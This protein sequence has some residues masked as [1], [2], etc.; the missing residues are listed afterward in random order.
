MAEWKT[1]ITDRTTND[2]TDAKNNQANVS[3][4]KGALNFNDLNRIENNYKYLLDRLKSE[5]YYINHKYRSYTETEAVVEK[6]DDGSSGGKITLP[7]LK[8]SGTQYIDTGFKPNNN[9]RVIMKYVVLSSG[10]RPTQALFGG[11]IADSNAMF[12]MFIINNSYFRP[13]YGAKNTLQITG[14]SDKLV[15]I[16]MNKETTTINGTS[17]SYSSETFQSNYSLTLFGV[18]DGGTVE[19]ATMA[20]AKL[21]SCQIYD[22]STLIRDYIPIKDYNN[23]ACLYDK[24][25]EQYYYNVGTG[26]FEY[27]EE[28]Y[29][30][31][32]YLESS[33]TQY[34]NTNHYITSQNLHYLCE[35]AYTG[36][37]SNGVPFGG[38]DDHNWIMAMYSNPATFWV[39]SSGPLLS[40]PM[41]TGVK[42]KFDLTANNGALTVINDGVTQTAT[43]SGAMPNNMPINLFSQRYPSGTKQFASV[44]I[45]YFKIYDN[46]VLVRNYVPVKD[47]TGVGYLFDKVSGI[48]YANAG[49]G[50]FA[51]GEEVSADPTPKYN[52][53]YIKTLYTDWFEQNLPWKSEMDRI[54]DNI[55]NLLGEYLQGKHI[56]PIDKGQYL[57][58]VEANKIEDIELITENTINQM[59]TQYRLCNTFKCGEG[60]FY[61]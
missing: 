52:I 26:T 30:Q 40:I 23:V 45:Y 31:V 15:L 59:K 54:R 38:G 7:Y 22:N 4:N 48:P 27:G 39:G 47:G 17:V 32:E 29:T 21:Y 34:I 8:S 51:A 53:Q 2:V 61:D 3:D 19:A 49:S 42:H 13:G 41:E 58:Y 33:G 36:D 5:G 57:D 10:N 14:T 28:I 1:P 16:D 12:E 18:N 56:T 44:R 20:T 24:V 50:S 55:N 60:R 9:T 46:N 11:R 25:N 35:M 37:N 6:I 43:Y